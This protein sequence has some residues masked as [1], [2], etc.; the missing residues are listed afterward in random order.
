MDMT[1]KF[2]YEVVFE[3]RYLQLKGDAFQDFF[4][5]LMEKRYGDDFYRVR[6]WGRAGDWKND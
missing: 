1:T 5:S 4:A 3:N 2:A 6:P